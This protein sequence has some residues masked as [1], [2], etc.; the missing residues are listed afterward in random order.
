MLKVRPVA[1]AIAQLMECLPSTD[2]PLTVKMVMVACVY[3]PNT[4]KVEPVGS[5]VQGHSQLL[6]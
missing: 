1:R 2:K 6:S 5:R 3:N 4:Q